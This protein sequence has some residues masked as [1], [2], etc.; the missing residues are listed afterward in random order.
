MKNYLI[1]CENQETANT[2]ND[3]IAV[4]SLFTEGE[5][6][7]D[8]VA[9]WGQ[10]YTD[11]DRVYNAVC[12][13]IKEGGRDVKIYNINEFDYVHEHIQLCKDAEGRTLVKRT[14][15]TV[16]H[17]KVDDN[18]ITV[19]G[20]KMKL[21]YKREYTF[22]LMKTYIG[23]SSPENLAHFIQNKLWKHSGHPENICEHIIAHGK[24]CA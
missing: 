10:S 3:Y 7:T 20:Y 9:R 11:D 8:P 17:V 5:T 15:T 12:A 4:N 19:N 18:S 13:Y 6:I 1:I 2:V 24:K 14:G 16:Y 23:T 22:K 21:A